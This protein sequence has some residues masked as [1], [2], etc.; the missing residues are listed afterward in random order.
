ME[1]I[2]RKYLRYQN[3]L[4]SKPIG[5]VIKEKSINNKT[6]QQTGDYLH[7]NKLQVSLYYEIILGI[8]RKFC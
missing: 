1:V 4:L 6:P 2:N 7:L 3:D 5:E 8:E